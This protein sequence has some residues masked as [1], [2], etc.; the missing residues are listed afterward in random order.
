MNAP[1]LFSFATSELSQDAFL[2]W[3]LAWSNPHYKSANATLQACGEAFVST[4][5][6]QKGIVLDHLENVEIRKQEKN[7]DVLCIVND[8]Y[9][10]LIEDKTGTSSHGDQLERYIAQVLGNGFGTECIVPIYFKT[11]DQSHYE[12]ERKNGYYPFTRQDA[13]KILERYNDGTNAILN[14]YTLRLQEIETWTKSYT[15]LPIHQWGWHS[16]IGFYQDLQRRLQDGNWKYVPN[17]SGGFLG[18]WCFWTGDLY[19]QL[20]QEKL[21][22]KVETENKESAKKIR[23]PLLQSALSLGLQG[24][25]AVQKPERMSAGKYTTFARALDNYRKVDQDGKIDM[26]ATV[27]AIED[28]GRLVQ[29]LS[30]DH[31]GQ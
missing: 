22:F 7:I 3:I 16:W 29:A 8:A 31:H 5:L 15:L 27:T 1:N 23:Q 20:E 25:M 11:T 4:F 21:C 13:L 12:H 30:K 28:A 9:V 18:M 17:P 14:D 10:I 26:D 2:C 24:Y 6:A 19:V